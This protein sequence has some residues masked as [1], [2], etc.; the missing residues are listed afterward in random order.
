MNCETCKQPNVHNHIL[1]SYIKIQP[2]HKD[3]VAVDDQS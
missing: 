3:P 2:S 1:S